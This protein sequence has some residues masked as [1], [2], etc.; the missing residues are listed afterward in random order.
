[1]T[2]KNEYTHLGINQV[3]VLSSLR[4]YILSRRST[5]NINIEGNEQHLFQRNAIEQTLGN[6]VSQQICGRK[7]SET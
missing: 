2:Y 1:M 6:L 7:N 5:V 3:E 4:K